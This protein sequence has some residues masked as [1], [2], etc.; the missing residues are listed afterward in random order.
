[1]EYLIHVANVLYL[2]S[3]LVRDIL[4]LRVLTVVAAVTLCLWTYTQIM[5][6]W[7]PIA[8]NAVFIAINAYQ[9]RQLLLERR[10]VN[11]SEREQRVYQRVFRSLTPR[12]FVKLLA[13][14]QWKIADTGEQLVEQGVPLSDM[15]VIVDGK[16]DVAVNGSCVAKLDEGSFVGEISFLTGDTPGASVVAI[17]STSYIAWPIERLRTFLR[18]NAELRAAWQLVIGT[19]L[20][21]KLKAA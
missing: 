4:W 7:A 19:D 12:E 8:W 13:V 15:M 21:Y 9:I 11:L 10:P 1:M 6:P 17:D 14:G 20:A 5:S 3:Y 2:F 16:V 18:D